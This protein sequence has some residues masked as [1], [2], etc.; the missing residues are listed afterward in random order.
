MKLTVI[1]GKRN[2]LEAK[3]VKSLF[4]GDI[5]EDDLE[6]LT[7]VRKLKLVSNNISNS[8]TGRPCL[9]KPCEK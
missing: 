6:R 9:K 7:L 3:V 2:E 4:T 1:K 5:K 8:S